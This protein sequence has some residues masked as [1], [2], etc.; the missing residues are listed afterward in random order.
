MSS[1]VSW[2][3][4]RV[5]VQ[6]CTDWL[7]NSD[8]YIAA[9]PAAGLVEQCCPQFAQ[10]ASHIPCETHIVDGFHSI[11]CSFVPQG[12]D[13][14]IYIVPQSE[15]KTQD[16]YVELRGAAGESTRL[17]RGG[18]GA[19]IEGTM[20]AKPGLLYVYVGAGGGGSEDRITQSGRGVFWGAGGGYSS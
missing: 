18:K 7:F 12:N 11:T 19:S 20:K 17:H 6:A 15:S 16:L 3:L 9:D 14:Y 8:H 5:G 2:F 1:I 10:Q 4:R 13:P